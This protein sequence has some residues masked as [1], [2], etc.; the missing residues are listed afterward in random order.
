MI[1]SSSRLLSCFLGM[2]IVLSLYSCKDDDPDFTGIWF[3]STEDDYQ[4]TA[5]EALITM[6]N[7]DTLHFRAGTYQFSTQLS[8]GDKTGIVIRGEGKDVTILDFTDQL[9]GAQAI[10]ATNMKDII[11]ADLTV[12]DMIGDGIKV[13][14]SEGVSFIRVG[15]VYTTAL[16]PQN[17]AYGLYPVSS[18]HVLVDEC[19]VRGASDAGIYVG[20]STQVHVRNSLVESCVAG[21]EIENCINSD[22]YGNT[23]TKNT[24]GILVFDLPTLPIIK[25]GNTTRVFDNDILLNVQSNFAP[26]GNAVGNVPEGT[27]IMILAFD[28]CEVF[29]NRISGNNTMGV[30]VVSYK[31]LEALDPGSAHSDTEYDPYVYNIH[32]HNNTFTRSASYPLAGE[33]GLI[34]QAVYGTYGIDPDIVIDGVINPDKPLSEQRICVYDN[35]GA[36]VAN[37]DAINEFANVITNPAEQNCTLEPLP[38]TIIQAPL[39]PY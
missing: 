17:G 13:K 26:P 9:S 39:L 15:A 35:G 34:L 19:Y 16:T 24:G 10:L 2:F 30:G 38:E 27:G 31:T 23:V 14:D 12:Q 5:Q 22:V 25:N 11:F 20:Q 36:M 3:I 4:T 32:I 28:R 18:S 37:L 21:I 7:Y 1:F 8:V 6:N 29:N 33:I